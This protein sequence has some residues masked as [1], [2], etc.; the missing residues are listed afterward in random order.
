MS[1][2]TSRTIEFYTSPARL[3]TLL[4]FSTMSTGIAA[5]LAFRLFP[6]MINDPAATSA[7]YTGMVFFSFCSAVAIWR[8][9]QQRGAAVTLSPAGLRDVRVAAEPIPWRAIKSIATLQMQRQMVLVVTIDPAEEGR[10]TLTRVARWTR[11]ANRRLG[12]HGLV[13]SP[14]GLTVGYPT[15]FYTCRDFWEAWRKAP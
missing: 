5:A 6:N 11:N 15:L 9:I 2:D 8:L 1:T 10:L 7:G 14:Q 13:V 12:A 4:L 3:I